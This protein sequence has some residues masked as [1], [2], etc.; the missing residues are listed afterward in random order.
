MNA[1]FSGVSRDTRTKE[2]KHVCEFLG[3]LTRLEPSAIGGGL[4]FA[5]EEGTGVSTGGRAHSSPFFFFLVRTK[6]S[7]TCVQAF[8]VRMLGS[9]LDGQ[10]TVIL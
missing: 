10:P 5:C 1:S 6:E 3:N 2:T 8:S 7:N 4:W 9:V